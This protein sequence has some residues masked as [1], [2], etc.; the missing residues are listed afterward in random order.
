MLLKLLKQETHDL[1]VEAERHVRI[2]DPDATEAQYVRYLQRMHGFHA[3]IE[4]AFATHPE[5]A[6]AG[7][8]AAGRAKRALIEADLAAYGATAGA[9]APVPDVGGLARGVGAAY[10]IEGST[11]GGAFILAKMRPQ[12]S[13]RFLAGYGDATGARW[14]AFGQI[15]TRVQDETA[16]IAAA[17]ETF[18]ALIA[19][20]DEPARPQPRPFYREARA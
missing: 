13:T 18:A 2:L 9:L 10:V 7:F 3:A 4:G 14:R 8:D 12:R 19:W 1:H 6:A 15:V 17:R 16:A 20:L 5:L 11:L